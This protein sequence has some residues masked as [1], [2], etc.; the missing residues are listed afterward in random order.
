MTEAWGRMLGK[1]STVTIAIGTP[2]SFFVRDFGDADPPDGDPR[3]RLPFTRD[4][5]FE[6]WYRITRNLPLGR[7]AILHPNAHSPLWGDSAAAS[8]VSRMLGEHGVTVEIVPSARVH[9]VAL[10]ERN[11]VIIGRPEYTDAAKAFLPE[12]ALTVEYSVT[13]RTVGIHNRSPKPGEPAWWFPS[14]G[15][16][17]NYGL[18]TV[19]TDAPA[20][21]K[22]VLLAGINSD[23]AEAG[24]R[25]LTSPDKLADLDKR[26]RESGLSQWPGSFQV[27]VRTESMDTYSLQTRFEFLR[28]WK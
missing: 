13:D 5:A 6:E 8:V 18:I 2:A 16:R 3:Y 12:D 28:I 10:R 15:L 11:A 20:R 17:H 4:K 19:V 21:T 26:F 25:F 1:G 14:D 24:A 7:T 27:V 22:T 23:G 9:P